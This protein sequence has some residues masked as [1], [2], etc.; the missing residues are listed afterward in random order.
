[1]SI[2]TPRADIYGQL[3]RRLRDACEQHG[4]ATSDD[5]RRDLIIPDGVHPSVVGAAVLGLV[6]DRA[7]VR[8]AYVRTTRPAGHGRMVGQYRL[9]TSQEA[10]Q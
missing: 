4:L 1:M 9:A 7:I 8:V 6:R 2:P 3:Q 10:A 5:A